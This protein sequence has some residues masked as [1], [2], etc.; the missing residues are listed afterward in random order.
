MGLA[1]AGFNQAPRL[2]NFAGLLQR[3]AIVTGFAWLTAL[4]VR[5]L[6]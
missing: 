1:G 2:V 6:R 4:C 5:A 3:M